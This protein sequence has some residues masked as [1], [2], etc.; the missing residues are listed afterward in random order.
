M[1]FEIHLSK[2]KLF[3]FNLIANNGE[4]VATSEM[5]FGKQGC[6]KGIRAVKMSMF[7]SVIDCT[8]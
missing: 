6:K 4:I 8:I 3:Y 7:A 2:D 1:K 5:Y